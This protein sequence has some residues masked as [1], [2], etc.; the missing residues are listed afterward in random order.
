MRFAFLTPVVWLKT[1]FFPI[2]GKAYVRNE[3]SDGKYLSSRC[4][5]HTAKFAY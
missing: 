2:K 4:W 5:G 3:N 1:I